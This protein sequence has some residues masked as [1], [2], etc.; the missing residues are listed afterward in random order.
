MNGSNGP[1]M[2][3]W[4]FMR[5]L[6]DSA[7]PFGLRDTPNFQRDYVAAVGLAAPYEAAL[8]HYS[9]ID[10]EHLIRYT[11]SPKVLTWIGNDSLAKDDLRMQAELWNFSYNLVPQTN[12]GAMIGTG[13]LYDKTYAEDHPGWGVKYGRS[14]GWGLD[15][16]TA[17]YAVASPQWRADHL[18]WFEESIDMLDMGAVHLRRHHSP[19]R[20]WATCSTV[21]TATVSQLKRASP[22]TRSGRWRAPSSRVRTKT[23][24]RRP[25]PF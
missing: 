16:M 21:S 5:P 14:E 13:L 6:L 18:R 25:T 2:P 12:N 15:T 19:R 1:F 7:D 24:V 20:R 10:I 8:L 3:A 17:Y 9:P 4:M 22:R 23:A 11:R